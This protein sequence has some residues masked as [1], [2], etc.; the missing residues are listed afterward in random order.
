MTCKWQNTT[1]IK[2]KP[3]PHREHAER[4]YNVAFREGLAACMTG[5]DAKAWATLAFDE[6]MK[7][8][9]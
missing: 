3:E 1:H 8:K 5:A 2:V 4:A 7:E 9:P 6:Q